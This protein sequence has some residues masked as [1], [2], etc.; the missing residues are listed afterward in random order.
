MG[1]PLSYPFMTIFV[2]TENAADLKRVRG[3][4]R[5]EL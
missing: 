3:V 5:C 4:E 1:S 2:A